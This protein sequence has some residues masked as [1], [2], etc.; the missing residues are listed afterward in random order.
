[1]KY[2]VGDLITLNVFQYPQFAHKKGIITS[3]NTFLI[4]RPYESYDVKFETAEILYVLEK[5]ITSFE[6]PAFS[7]GEYV[8]SKYGNGVIR[9]IEYPYYYIFIGSELYV[10]HETEITCRISKIPEIYKTLNIDY[11]S[12]L[13]IGA[14]GR[15]QTVTN[16][17]ISGKTYNCFV[18]EAWISTKNNTKKVWYDGFVLQESVKDVLK[19]IKDP[20]FQYFHYK[21]SDDKLPDNVFFNDK[22]KATTLMFGKE[23]TVVKCGKDDEYSRRIGFLEAYF[24]AT[25]GLSKTKAKKYLENIVKDKEEKK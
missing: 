1:M 22:K 11:T 23:A 12:G 7:V 16:G 14:E 3:V 6:R 10:I 19:E 5:W 17:D 24:Q 15:A 25:C 13:L 21:L 9:K 2:K 4:E 8:V 18:N 20:S